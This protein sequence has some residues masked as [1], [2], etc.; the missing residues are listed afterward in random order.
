MAGIKISALPAVGSAQL[1][2]IF[3]VVQGGVTYKE[4]STQLATLFGFSGGVLAVTGGGT[5][6]NSISA[7]N[8]V[9]GNAA[10]TG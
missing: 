2:D 5:G 8:I 4:T 9:A 6:V 7:Y 10:G 3:P 1:T